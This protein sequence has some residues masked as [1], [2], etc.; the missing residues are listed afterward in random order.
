MNLSDTGRR[1]HLPRGDLDF[2]IHNLAHGENEAV[3]LLALLTDPETVDRLLDGPSI[4]NVVLNGRGTLGISEFLYFYLLVRRVFRDRGLEDPDLADYVAG[5]LADFSLSQR[6]KKGGRTA[7][8][9][10]IDLAEDLSRATSP[11]ERFFLSVQIG[12]FL[13]VATGIFYAHLEER[14]KRRGAPGLGYYEDFGAGIFREAGN[15]PLAREFLL[16]DRFRQLSDAFSSSRRALN[17]MSDQFLI[18]N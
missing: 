12:N 11:Y 10:V 1:F 7:L 3:A 6:L 5:A 16:E 18:W 13:L 14:S 2:L 9:F 8:P 4:L 17:R 15:H